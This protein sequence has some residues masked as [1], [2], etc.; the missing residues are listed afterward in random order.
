MGGAPKENAWGGEVAEHVPKAVFKTGR[1]PHRTKL[2]LSRGSAEA[3]RVG[4]P[5]C[6]AKKIQ[7][8]VQQDDVVLCVG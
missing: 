8:V 6:R 2:R 3:K 7:V 1:T 5:I 4:T